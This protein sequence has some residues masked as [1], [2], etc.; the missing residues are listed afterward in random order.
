EVPTVRSC[1]AA[2]LVLGGLALGR[3]A[4]TLRLVAAGAL[5]VLAFWP[6]ALVGPSFQMSFAAVV[7]IIALGEHRGFRA[8]VAARDET[9]VRRIGRVLIASLMTGFAVELVLAPIALFHFHKAG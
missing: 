6:E 1:V 2:L 4:L 3:D 5:V 8:L 7:A 9:V